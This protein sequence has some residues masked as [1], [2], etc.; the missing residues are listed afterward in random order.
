MGN[1]SIKKYHQLD[2]I[3]NSLPNLLYVSSGIIAVILTP[4]HHLTPHPNPTRRTKHFH[5]QLDL[6]YHHP[7]PHQHHPPCPLPPATP[8]APPGPPSLTTKPT[9]SSTTCSSTDSRPEAWS[10]TGA[11]TKVTPSGSHSCLA[12][13]T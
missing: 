6:H 8:N 7:P 2:P 9:S 5:S 12:F 4:Y 3:K 10:S 11:P 1:I 13:C